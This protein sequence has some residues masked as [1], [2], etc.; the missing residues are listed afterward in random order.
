MYYSNLARKNITDWTHYKKKKKKERGE[1]SGELGV[2]L[3]VQAG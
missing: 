2:E 1:G 3:R